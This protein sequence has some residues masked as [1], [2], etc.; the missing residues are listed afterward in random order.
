MEELDEVI[1]DT[2]S[3]DAK[4]EAGRQRSSVVKIV[5][6]LGRKSELLEL[7]PDLGLDEASLFA[8]RRDLSKESADNLREKL[9]KARE[10]RRA[11]LDAI[12]SAAETIQYSP[13]EAD[14][15]EEE[16]VRTALIAHADKLDQCIR[17]IEL[18]LQIYAK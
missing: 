9:D 15:L 13:S 3:E 11:A 8:Q 18:L 2:S 4:M 7:I 16:H 1:Q 10:V 14:C 17:A 12:E 6:D 5:R